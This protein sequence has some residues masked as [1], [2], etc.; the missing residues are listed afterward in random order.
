[1]NC[2]GTTDKG[3]SRPQNQDSYVI[4]RHDEML[5]VC[6]CDG[7]GGAKAGDVASQSAVAALEKYFKR[8]LPDAET[9]LGQW[10][11]KA[12]GYV[13][14]KVYEL[15]LTK[16]DYS[17][18][19]TTLIAALF[20]AAGGA[21]I[22]IGDS[23][24]YVLAA[25]DQLVQLTKDHT[26]INDLLA[27]GGMNEEQLKISGL[28]HVIT[29]AVGVWPKIEGDCFEVSDISRP[30]LICSDGLYNSVDA[31][32]I[33]QTLAGPLDLAGQAQQLVK[34]ANENGGPDNITLII[35]NGED[36]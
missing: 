20:S 8:Q 30:V 23:R 18:M 16:D 4:C 34:K 22:N 12:A 27:K 19:G 24:G 28:T 7:I 3:I 35:V 13:N 17:G 31:A 6:V 14:R 33:R 36:V 25:D 15:S 5:L 32:F 11:T 21:V 10:L 2:Y 9:D 26:L 29:K 1:M